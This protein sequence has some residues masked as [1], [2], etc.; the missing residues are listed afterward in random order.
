MSVSVPDRIRSERGRSPWWQLPRVNA[1][2]IPPLLVELWWKRRT[3]R[4]VEELLCLTGA[5]VVGFGARDG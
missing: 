3:R 5:T 2:P 4:R 1:I